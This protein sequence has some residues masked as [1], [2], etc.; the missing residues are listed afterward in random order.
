MVAAPL[1]K[2]PMAHR[3]V[4]RDAMLP[5]AMV[6][7]VSPNTALA[8]TQAWIDASDACG[9]ETMDRTVAV[10]SANTSRPEPGSGPTTS[11]ET[12]AISGGVLSKLDQM[13]AVQ[14]PVHSLALNM[15]QT[16]PA[17]IDCTRNSNRIADSTASQMLGNIILGTQSV[18]I[19][20]TPFDGDW[21]AAQT[22]PNNARVQRALAKSGARGVG[23]KMQQ[24]EVINRW[25]NEN[26]AFGEDQAVYG[27]ADYWAPASE[28]LRRGTGDC[29]DFAITKM[30][31]LAG[32]G[33]A[34]ADM[35]LIIARDLVRNADHAV[36]V[37]RLNSGAVMLDNVTD[38]LLDA[39]VSHDYRPI[40][41]FSQNAKWVHGY[42]ARQ[43][44]PIGLAA[45]PMAVP[46][47]ELA[48]DAIAVTAEP[49][50]PVISV[51]WLSAPLVFP[52][53]R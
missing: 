25:V 21:A 44:D 2:R 1:S 15:A 14:N 30:D 35:R 12:S 16:A 10:S 33:V 45:L 50:L 31:M 3:S 8:Q 36:L 27:R 5:M 38:G 23:D 29:E 22:Q 42:A 39:R 13:R 49:E 53:L 4:L 17:S 19:T 52:N 34:R 26:I 11:L 24:V 28:T 41:S 9:M 46:A 32:L 20:R 47:T 6:L 37:V 40:M 7:S 43:P 51:A 18:A 48:P